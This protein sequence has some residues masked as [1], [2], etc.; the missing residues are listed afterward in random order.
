[1]AEASYPLYQRILF[2][3][4]SISEYLFRFLAPVKLY[5]FYFFPIKS[6][7]SLP[8]YYW[9]YLLILLCVGLFVVHHYRRNNKLVLFGLLF[10][11]INVLLVLHI[12][13]MPREMITAD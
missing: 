11:V 9:G 6:G 2:G 13:P 10:F 1:S 12:I 8:W 4:H 3:M 5:Y 7:D